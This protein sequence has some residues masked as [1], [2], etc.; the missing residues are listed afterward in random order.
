MRLDQIMPEWD[1]REIH[2]IPLG[3][4][5]DVVFRAI[6]E[7]TWAEVPVFRLLMAL[8]FPKDGHA[9]GRPILADM[10]GGGFT[11]LDRDSGEVVIGSLNRVGFGADARLPEVAPGP[12]LRAFATPGFVKIAFNFRLADGVLVTETR[13]RGTDAR[14]RRWFRPYWMVIR[15][16]S[17]LIRRV[18]LAAIRRRALAAVAGSATA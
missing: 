9:A 7:T 3:A 13:V 10:L 14:A 12:A 18:W 1:H 16:P 17:G 6:E 11:L 15:L 5:P 4:A 2:R 8:R